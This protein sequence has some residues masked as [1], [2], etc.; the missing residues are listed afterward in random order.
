[1][2]SETLNDLKVAI[3]VTDGSEQIEMTEPR[4]AL[5]EAGAETRLVSPKDGRVKAW[6]FTDWGG[7]FPVDMPLDSARSEALTRSCCRVASS[8]PTCSARCPRRSRS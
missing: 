6:N 2:T 7:T 4:K 8:T 3:L 1:M 5:D